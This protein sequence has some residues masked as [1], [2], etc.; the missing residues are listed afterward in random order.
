MEPDSLD[1][2]IIDELRRDARQSSRALA[3]RLGVAAGTVSQRIGRLEDAGVLLGYTAV[4]DEGAIGRGMGFVVGLQMNQGNQMAAALDELAALPEV[5][6]VLVVTGRWDLLVLG[7]VA[8]P[9]E[10]NALLTEGLWESPSFRHSET[11]L[12]ID[13]R[14]GDR[15]GGAVRAQRL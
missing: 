3:R 11:L 8:G 1:R 15:D 13:R 6:E 9:P 5:D 10:L 14:T 7:R 2:R 4:V 12:V